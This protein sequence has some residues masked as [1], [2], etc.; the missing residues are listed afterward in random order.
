MVYYMLQIYI[1]DGMLFKV[2]VPASIALD[3][4]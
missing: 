1:D 4:G 2:D 3:Q